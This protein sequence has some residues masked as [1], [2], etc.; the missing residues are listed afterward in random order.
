MV[1]PVVH[2]GGWPGS[3]K[4]TIGRVVADTLRGRL[5][6]N[7]IM[8]DAARAIYDRGMPGS[9][10]LREEVRAVVMSHA[11][12]LPGDVPII[13]T[14]ALA[15]EPAARPLFEPTVKLAEKR[16]ADLVTFVLDLSPEENLRRLQAPERSGA[17]KLKDPNVLS[18]IRRKDRLFCPD[19]C[20]MLDV[21][22]L[23]PKQAAQAICDNIGAQL[24]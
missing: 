22:D 7:H 23:T 11:E 5:I 9:A 18:D 1:A 19:G 21:T 12:K 17:A 6:D 13:L 15:D 20:T 16:S 8:L 3:G 14:D 2:I 24:A 4:R 10:E